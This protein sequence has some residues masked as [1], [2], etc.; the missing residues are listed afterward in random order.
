MIITDD[1]E[2]A[3]AKHITTTAKVPHPYDF[4][5]DQI[6]YNYRMPNL[7]AAIGCAQMEHLSEFLIIKDKITKKWQDFLS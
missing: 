4:V 7:N 6:G 1:Y 3:K 5:H 2:L